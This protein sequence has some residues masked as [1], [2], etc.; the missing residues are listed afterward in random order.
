MGIL[1]EIVKSNRAPILFIGSGISKR[2]LYNYPSWKELLEGSFDKFEPD[3]F[4]YQKQI[5]FCKRSNMTEFETNAYMGSF[6]E[7]RFNAAFFDRKIIL[8][9]G[10]KKNPSWVRRGISPYKMYLADFFKKQK[11]YKS[12]IMLEELE[13]FKKL[14]N[15]ISA[16]ITTN[17]DT[18]L[19]KYVFPNDFTV[20]V[21]QH[22]LFSADSYNI[23]EIYKIHGSATD[24]ESII[25]TKKD[26]DGFK[27][28]RKLI[29]AKML[30]LFAESPIIFMGYSFTDEDV[31]NIIE[32]FLSCLSE[33]QLKDIRKHFVFVSYKKDEMDLIEIERTITTENGIEIPFVEIQTD[34]YGKVY[35]KLGE[36]IPGISPI[37]VR[38]TRRVVKKIVDQNMASG[39]AE[40]IIVGIDNLENIDLSS[41]PLA[42]AIGYKENILNKYGYGLL[43]DDQILEDIVYDNKKFDAYQMCFE[44]FKSIQN[45]RLLPVFKYTKGQNIPD[46]SK[47]G[48]FMENRNS[49]S[50]IIAKYVEKS[51]GNVSRVSSYKEVKQE[52]VEEAVCRKASM[53]VLRNINILSNDELRDACKYLFETYPELDSNAKRCIMCLDFRENYQV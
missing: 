33:K 15:K 11:L 12:D 23:A 4:Q 48:Q 20:F 28:S 16:V 10:N 39:K 49:L 42:I 9:I 32:D 51:L 27:E 47:L 43:E 1:D 25:I 37:R 19:E 35:D 5:D 38:E 34:N 29:I 3:S 2:Y 53:H 26:Y 21:R 46:D 50:K 36:I 24:A 14:N 31:R 45:N 17:Y 44:R 30:T 22:D 41:K 40:S 6:I 8:N 13:K 7:E 18:F 52:M